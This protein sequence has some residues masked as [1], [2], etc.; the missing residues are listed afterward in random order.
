MNFDVCALL[1]IERDDGQD[2][3]LN[4]IH[5]ALFLDGPIERGNQC[6]DIIESFYSRAEF[7]GAFVE[8][9]FTRSPLYNRLVC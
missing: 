9:D 4:D 6:A 1:K 8:E 5:Q 2:Q 3:G 7:P